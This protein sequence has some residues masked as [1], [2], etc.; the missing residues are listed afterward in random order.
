[1][2]LLST[3]FLMNDLALA[4]PKRDVHTEHSYSHKQ[5]HLCYTS[6]NHKLNLRVTASSLD[7]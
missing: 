5:T 3:S 2:E 7:C 1:M 4:I 6:R